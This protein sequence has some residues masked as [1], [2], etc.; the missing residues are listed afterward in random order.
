[1]LVDFEVTNFLSF[2]ESSVLSLEKGK[3][4]K[5]HAKS[6]VFE[7]QNISLLKNINIFGDNG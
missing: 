7:K 3:Y 6:H 5:K 1:M 4:L 2:R